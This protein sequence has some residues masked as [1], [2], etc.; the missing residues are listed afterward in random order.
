MFSRRVVNV[1]DEILVLIVAACEMADEVRWAVDICGRASTLPLAL[2]IAN[3][4]SVVHVPA[5]TV[6][7][8]RC[9]PR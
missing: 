1:E 9:L 3:G 2:L 4:Q 5:R 7:H 8:V 6:N